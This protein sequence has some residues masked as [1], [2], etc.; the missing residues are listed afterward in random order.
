MIIIVYKCS[1]YIIH[2]KPNADTASN[3]FQ[4]QKKTHV[5]FLTPNAINNVD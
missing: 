5:Y 2:S 4:Y 1:F 3:L